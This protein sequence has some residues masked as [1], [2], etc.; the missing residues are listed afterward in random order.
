MSLWSYLVDIA[1]GFGSVY[2]TMA[3]SIPN[4]NSNRR[5]ELHIQYVPWDTHSIQGHFGV[6]LMSP[7][8]MYIVLRQRREIV[9]HLSLLLEAWKDVFGRRHWHFGRYN[10]T[11]LAKK[12][13][14]STSFLLNVNSTSDFQS[15]PL[16]V[17]CMQVLY[18]SFLWSLFKI[19]ILSI[20]DR[21]RHGLSKRLS[22]T[23]KV[24]QV[25]SYC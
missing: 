1:Q 22:Y 18:A 9:C 23:P 7:C 16:N 19:E 6:R 15:K 5:I 24:T 25:L 21:W 2:T 3:F 12:R 20:T 17:G 13:K 10:L 4:Y 8:G 11:G 14:L